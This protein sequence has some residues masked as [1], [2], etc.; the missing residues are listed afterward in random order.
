M[1]TC[2]DDGQTFRSDGWMDGATLSLPEAFLMNL[3]YLQVGA[4]PAN[5]MDDG[6]WSQGLI[7]AVS[8]LFTGSTRLFKLC[9]TR[10]T[11]FDL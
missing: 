7:S 1:V 11:A 3:L 9:V 8:P 2:L 5:A 4:I 6:Q 10:V